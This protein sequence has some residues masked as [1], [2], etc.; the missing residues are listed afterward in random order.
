MQRT[1]QCPLPADSDLLE[2]I[3]VYNKAV[4]RV[5][6]IGWTKQTYN[7]NR[8]HEFSYRDL[9]ETYP[10]LQSSLIQCARDMASDMLKR[11]KFKHKKPLKKPF[12][13]VRYN[14]RTFTP[15]LDSGQI[16]ISTLTGRKRYSLIVSKYF[17]RYF[18]GRITSLT[19]YFNKRRKK[20]IAH[21]TMEIPDVPVEE[22]SSFLGVDR[23]I[24]RIAVCSNNSFYSTNHILAV[25]WRYQQLRKKLQ[26]KGSRSSKRK[27]KQVSGRERRFMTDENRKIA[28]WVCN[29]P[30]NCIVL[31]NIRGLKAHSKQKKKVN[32][33]VRRQFGNWS[34]YQLERFIIERAEKV[35]KTVLYVNPRY[36]SQRCSRCEYISKSNR[37][38]QSHFFCRECWFELNADLNAARNLSDF[39]KAE[40]G[41][42]SVNSPNVAVL[43]LTETIVSLSHGV[44]LAT[45]H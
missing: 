28:K 37:S 41:R 8:L 15:F 23:G 29:M 40:I 21:L 25:K 26:S 4:Q 43:S 16:S 27:L 31:E 30:Y 19:L 22:P 38:S 34:Y 7:K 5:I 6:D 32:K 20:I 2:T 10:K 18:E 24:K 35:G 12:S 17:Q 1:I 33:K 42:A 11:E 44:V 45:S 9:R 13:G 3:R 39:G 36:T 14:Q